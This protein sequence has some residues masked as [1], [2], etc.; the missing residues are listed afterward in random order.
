MTITQLLFPALLRR[1][2]GEEANQAIGVSGDV[3]GDVGIIDPQTAEAGFAAEDDRSHWLGGGLLIILEPH[4]EIDFD[5]GLRT[6]G[7]LAKVI[8]E[9]LRVAPGVAVDVDDHA[10]ETPR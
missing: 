9:V 4:G 1:I 10:R 6:T 7:L 3:V 8:G 2:E 5:A